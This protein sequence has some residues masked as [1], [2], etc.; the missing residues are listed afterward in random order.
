VVAVA[1][2]DF[3][4]A[5]CLTLM[6]SFE[7]EKDYFLVCVC[8]CVCVRVCARIKCELKRCEMGALGA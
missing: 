4:S 8:V 5:G 1:E 2:R 6:F 7:Y 3:V